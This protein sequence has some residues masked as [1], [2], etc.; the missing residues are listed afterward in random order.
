[1]KTLV[2]LLGVLV[3]GIALSGTVLSL[4]ILFGFIV[5]VHWL[6][7]FPFYLVSFVLTLTIL[8]KRTDDWPPKWIWKSRFQFLPEAANFIR[9]GIIL[10]AVSL[11]LGGII[12]YYDAPI[13]PVE[14]GVYAGKGR[15]RQFT[16]HQYEQFV[17]WES[18]LGLAWP[19]MLLL[20]AAT[21]PDEVRK[22]RKRI[23]RKTNDYHCRLRH[24]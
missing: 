1:M 20:Y 5:P 18:A 17:R 11:F 4:A 14:N 15:R 22:K 24:Q 7:A 2:Q 6:V 19:A 12:M 8:K 9:N 13:R 3:V 16:R 23:K 21:T 10:Y